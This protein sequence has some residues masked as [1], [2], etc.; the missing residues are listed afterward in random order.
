MT[1]G[2]KFFYRGHISQGGPYRIV[3]SE[4]CY[5]ATDDNRRDSNANEVW[6]AADSRLFCAYPFHSLKIERQIVD[7]STQWLASVDGSWLG[8]ETYVYNAM[9]RKAEKAAQAAT[10]LFHGSVSLLHS[11]LAVLYMEV[12]LL[13][14]RI[15]GGMVAL[16]PRR[17]WTYMK[18]LRMRPKP[19]RQPQTL[20]SCQG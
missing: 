11:A 7:V 18:T 12:Y 6:N 15:R 3:I 8:C 20:L 4:N 13:C 9:A 1:I 2:L 5:S 16:S 14:A 19:M 10:V 17:F